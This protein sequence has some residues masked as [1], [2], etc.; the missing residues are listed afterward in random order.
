MNKNWFLFKVHAEFFGGLL[1]GIL[2]LELSG[3]LRSLR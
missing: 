1:P 3:S 2:L